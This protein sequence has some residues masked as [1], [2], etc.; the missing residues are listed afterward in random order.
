MTIEQLDWFNLEVESD[1]W[2]DETLQILDQVV[3]TP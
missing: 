2:E 3:E 1:E